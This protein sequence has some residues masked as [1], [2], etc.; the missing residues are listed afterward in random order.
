MAVDKGILDHNFQYEYSV[1]PETYDWGRPWYEP[2]WWK[3]GDE[4]TYF[5]HAGGL[6]LILSK[7][8]AQYININ[9]AILKTYAHDDI[10]V[11]SW[12]MGLQATYIDDSHLCCG[13]SGQG[14][15]RSTAEASPPPRVPSAGSLAQRELATNLRRMSTKAKAMAAEGL[16]LDCGR[17]CL[18]QIHG[19]GAFGATMMARRQCTAIESNSNLLW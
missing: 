9:S 12:M 10:S 11:G 14:G 4:K 19:A 15:N 13:S 8:M 1:Q 7:N 17:R 6:L 18:V 16:P 3:F 2:E 5:R